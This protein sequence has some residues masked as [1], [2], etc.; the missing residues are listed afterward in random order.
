MTDT[1]E[2]TETGLDGNFKL[3]VPFPGVYS[4]EAVA[5]GKEDT[6]VTELHAPAEGIN[7]QMKDAPGRR[8]FCGKTDGF[9]TLKITD[10]GQPVHW[11]DLAGTPFGGAENTKG[12]WHEKCTSFWT[13]GPYAFSASGDVKIRQEPHHPELRANGWF[14]GDFHAHLTHGENIYKGNLPLFAFAAR[15]EHYDWLWCSS[16]F[17]NDGE[18]TDYKR[19]A[20]A[21]CDEH[22]LL[23]LNTEFP[24]TWRG[25]VG[26]L[27]VEP[28]YYVTDTDTVTNFEL[29]RLCVT[30]KGGLTIPVH[31]LYNDVIREDNGRKYSWMTGKEIFLWLLCAPEMIPC[32]DIF[33]NND[34][35]DASEFW[36]MLLNCGYRIGCTAT[37]DAAFDVG[38]TPGSDRGATFVKADTLS[39]QGILAGLRNRR[40]VVTWDGAVVL[41]EIDGKT[42]GDILKPDGSERQIKLTVYD[43]PGKAV[44]LKLIRNGAIYRT[45]SAIVPDDGKMEYSQEIAE[46][47]ICWYLAELRETGKPEC[48]RS[49]ASPIYFRDERFKEPEVLP[50]P[51][52][53]SREFLDY[54]KFLSIDK[55]TDPATFEKFRYYL[56]L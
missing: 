35:P 9:A 18:I 54:M 39:E 56:T 11:F 3:T 17:G 33:Y 38:R 12:K 46:K 10:N 50:P 40:T 8:L 21:L 51:A 31:P 53:F 4:L 42:S 32:I 27:G 7:I 29:A 13:R 20:D 28:I 43:R 2:L 24:K 52:S 30:S 14:K 6:F 44:E 22:F 1:G 36:Y 5:E 45:F 16:A 25:H 47:E 41:L 34:T 37:S 23:R 26:N 49:A 19:M 55:L 48:I 15:A